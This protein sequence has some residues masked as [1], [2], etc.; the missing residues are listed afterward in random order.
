MGK[1]VGNGQDDD[2]FISSCFSSLCPWYAKGQ[3]WNVGWGGW[4][5]EAAI[6]LELL[7][8]FGHWLRSS[9]LSTLIPLSFGALRSQKHS[10][11]SNTQNWA[12]QWNALN[13]WTQSLLIKRENYNWKLQMI[14][15][16]RA[17]QTFLLHSFK[18]MSYTEQARPKCKRSKSS[19]F[20]FCA[21]HA[22]SINSNCSVKMFMC[23]KIWASCLQGEFCAS[24]SCRVSSCWLG[25]WVD[26]DKPARVVLAAFPLISET[27]ANQVTVAEVEP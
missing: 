5:W 21:N 27:E 19:I 24:C 17:L 8:I 14:R 15:T 22:P 18:T 13:N 9:V 4:F 3:R 7:P 2:I 25:C 6:I 20:G 23:N 1:R 16:V 12:W 10:L 11:N 26:I